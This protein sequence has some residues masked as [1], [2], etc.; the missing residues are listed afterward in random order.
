MRD[1]RDQACLDT[2]LRRVFKQPRP[3]AAASDALLN[4]GLDRECFTNTAE[5]GGKSKL[6]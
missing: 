5:N 3:K 4:T 1:P 6:A 2:I